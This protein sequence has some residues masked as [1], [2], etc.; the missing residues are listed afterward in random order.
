ML[1]TTAAALSPAPK[2]KVAAKASPKPAAQPAPTP[3]DTPAAPPVVVTPKAKPIGNPADWFA[4]DAY[5]PAARN[6]GQ[7]GRTVFKVQ[8]DPLG[9]IMECDIVETSGS[10]LLDNATCD[11]IVTHGRFAP[12][13][14]ASGQ[15]V[16]G[17]WQS[18]MRWQLV[19][20]APTFDPETDSE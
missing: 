11:Q 14:N 3:T 15:A 19:A 12:A 10:M 8:V 6:A 5:P 17:T 2:H 20:A 7:E 9:R 16:A 18:A 4:T 1:A 13:R